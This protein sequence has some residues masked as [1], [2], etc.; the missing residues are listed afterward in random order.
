MV[1][2]R[3]YL[4]YLHQLNV[5]WGHVIAIFFF[6]EHREQ[7]LGLYQGVPCKQDCSFRGSEEEKGPEGKAAMY[8]ALLI[9]VTNV[10][11]D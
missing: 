1:K 3:L 2:E 8:F 6:Q 5:C 10:V 4:Q 7:I 11:L 9:N